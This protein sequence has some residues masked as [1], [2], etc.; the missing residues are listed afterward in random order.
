[1]KQNPFLYWTAATAVAS[2]IMLSYIHN[3]VYTRVEGDKLEKRVEINSQTNREDFNR[4]QLKVDAIYR[5]LSQR[6]EAEK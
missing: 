6:Q 3:F 2:V 5:M 4:L 1:M